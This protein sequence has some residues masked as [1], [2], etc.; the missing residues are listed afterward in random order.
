MVRLPEL[1]FKTI[2]VGNEHPLVQEA[3]RQR[4]PYEVCWC[5]SG[6]KFKKCHRFREQESALSLGQMLD[7]QGRVFWKN[8]GCMHLNA[9]AHI[10]AGKVVDAHTIQRK[11]PLQM[12]IGS[13]NHVCHLTPS[14]GEQFIVE[15]L[16][17]R[18]ASTFPGYCAKHDTEIFG[19][20]ERSTFTGTHEQCVLQAYRNVCNELYKKRALIESLEYQRIA[21][22]RGCD[23][24]AQI[25][26]QLS[27]SASIAGHMKSKDELE[28]LWR[29]FED[30][31]AR[32]QYDRFLSKC[33]F[34]KGDLSVTSS[35]TLHT[36]FDFQGKLLM[37]MWNLETDAEMLSHS[38][39]VTDD[40]G[41]IVFTWL[42]DE[43]LPP[44]VVSTFDQVADDSKGDIFVQYCF[45][46]CENTYFS[47]E[48]WEGLNSSR[49]EQLKRY[50]ETLFYEGGTFVANDDRLVKWNFQP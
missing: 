35:G 31:I 42:A 34:F 16:G 8:R 36:E 20:L 17:W 27:V 11:G 39:M 44:S 26:R 46:N 10:C 19:V 29:K 38:I 15:E 50:A 13:D 37:D 24:D 33:Y 18:K 6:R 25:A 12:I 7:E 40:G 5:G 28:T 32:Q 21:I 22:D 47:K 43:M 4:K 23:L 48:W 14:P 1:P 9:S 41:A 3:L 30:A 2:D 49:Q 45:L